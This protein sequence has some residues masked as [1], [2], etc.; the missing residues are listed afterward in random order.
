MSA[1]MTTSFEQVQQLTA[2]HGARLDPVALYTLTGGWSA[3]VLAAVQTGDPLDAVRAA[4][5]AFVTLPVELCAALLPL[6][7]QQYWHPVRSLQFAPTL[8]DDWWTSLEASDLPLFPAPDGQ[9]LAAPALLQA[10]EERLAISS[11]RLFQALQ[12]QAATM[13]AEQGDTDR[14]IRAYRL[15]SDLGAAAQL[16]EEQLLAQAAKGTHARITE[17]LQDIHPDLLTA[18][19][20]TIGLAAR[21]FAASDSRERMSAERELWEQYR[22]GDRNRLL[23]YYLSH[24][25]QRE[26]RFVRQLTLTHEGLTGTPVPTGRDR[27]CLLHSQQIACSRLG[28]YAEQLA[29]CQALLEAAEADGDRLFQAH[30]HN[31][32]ASVYEDTGDRERAGQAY[33]RALRLWE[34]LDSPTGRVETLNNHAQLLM[35][36]QRPQEAQALLETGLGIPGLPARWDAWLSESLATVYHQYGEIQRV[37]PLLERAL[38]LFQSEQ[39]TEDAF[40]CALMLAEHRAMTGNTAGARVALSAAVLPSETPEH[41]APRRFTQGVVALLSA[42]NRHDAAVHF[43]DALEGPLSTWNR[44]RA[45]AYLTAIR[46]R[47]GRPASAEIRQLE[48]ALRDHGGDAPL[49]TDRAVLTDLW[50]DLRSRLGW[51]ARLAQVVEA[52]ALAG[53]HDLQVALF[54]R[55][56]LLGP[57]GELRITLAKSR[58]LLAF[59]L[60]HGPSRRAQIIAALWDGN[61]S[62]Q[63]VEYFKVSVKKLREALRPVGLETPLAVVNGRY[64]LPAE[65]R[66]WTNVDLHAVFPA[67]VLDVRAGR[68]EAGEF[69]ESLDSEWI[70][71]ARPAADALMLKQLVRNLNGQPPEAELLKRLARAGVAFSPHD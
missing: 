7:T 66:C 26:G 54:G 19:V 8:P 61:A 35:G 45:R 21:Y 59:L 63:T 30:A 41:L 9:R 52:G 55:F 56:T 48:D 23:L 50:T 16:L 49:L 11:P 53:H 13:A 28:Q 57:Q 40:S 22:A 27:L 25:E 15:A 32:L 4:D 6:C 43:Q 12:R 62:P 17:L 2:T 33:G 46:L 14:A 1:E 18:R 71:E 29:S 69:L 68:P 36:E 70:R 65:L 37:M 39:M 42:R 60:L 44:V 67:S 5:R 51:T 3:G 64:V 34:M 47:A 31:G 24:F 20:R 58:E 38:G 10:M